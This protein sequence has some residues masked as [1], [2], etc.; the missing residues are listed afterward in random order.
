MKNKNIYIKIRSRKVK[1]KVSTYVKIKQSINKCINLLKKFIF[2]IVELFRKIPS[3]IYSFVGSLLSIIWNNKKITASLLGL[4]SAPLL[5]WYLKFNPLDTVNKLNK[6][7]IEHVSSTN[8]KPTRGIIVTN[9]VTVTN[10]IVKEVT[11]T[12]VI[13]IDK[14]STTNVVIIINQ[15]SSYSISNKFKNRASR[16]VYVGEDYQSSDNYYNKF[17]FFR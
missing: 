10:T 13:G 16:G 9:N 8:D 11:V 14:Q 3:G 15:E 1:R 17:P 12:N 6:P 2:W 7:K 4:I 5:S